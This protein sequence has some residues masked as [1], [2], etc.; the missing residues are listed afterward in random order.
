MV[1]IVPHTD[2]GK[3]AVINKYEDTHVAFHEDTEIGKHVDR[4]DDD[5]HWGLCSSCYRLVED[6]VGVDPE[7]ESIMCDS[8]SGFTHYVIP[9]T[10]D[11][12]AL[13]K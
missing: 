5:V 1:T 12:D 2:N 4:V 11:H 9:H 3:M 8:C 7:R 6:G 10:S 13:K